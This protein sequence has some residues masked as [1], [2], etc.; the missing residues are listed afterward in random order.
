MLTS[1]F[2]TMSEA[3]KQQLETYLNIKESVL[4]HEDFPPLPNAPLHSGH[5]FLDIKASSNKA[6]KI[7]EK[8]MPLGEVKAPETHSYGASPPVH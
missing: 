6:M 8:M 1:D 2:P 5:Q 7:L 4:N 3:G